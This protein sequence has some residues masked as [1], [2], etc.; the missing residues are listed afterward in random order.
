V[1]KK[2]S[3]ILLAS[4]A[5]YTRYSEYVAWQIRQA[6]LEDIPIF[7]AS[8]DAKPSELRGLSAD[9]MSI[10]VSG[11]ISK[12]PQSERLR[13][14]GYW[15]IPGI[16]EAA[17]TYDRILYLDSDIH[18]EG[19][20]LEKLLSI[21]MQGAPIAAVRDVHQSVRPHR[22]ANEFKK[23]GWNNAPYFNAG[24][25]LIDGA[26]FLRENAIEMIENCAQKFPEALTTYDQSLLNIAY[27]ENWLELSP[28]WNWQLSH[29]NFQI[30]PSF[31]IEL[32]HVVGETKPWSEGSGYIPKNIL[33]KYREFIGD[34]S[35]RSVHERRAI[36]DFK[37]VLKNQ[38]YLKNY[39]NWV[40]R[41][42]S[43]FEGI[44]VK[45]LNA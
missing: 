45:D 12:L 34:H 19:S 44:L 1:L 38:W 9:I 8:A 4:S 20:N 39:R 25:M 37:Y 15:R 24:V 6:G 22:E 5:S 42:E 33:M 10:Q 14:F 32:I 43:K 29:R 40:E 7:I 26:K 18:V 21:D 27:Y 30:Y 17:K 13:E 3:C 36:N 23:L 41:F 35:H 31:D 11:F 28:V 2:K 16:A